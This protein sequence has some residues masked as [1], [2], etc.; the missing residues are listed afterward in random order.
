M[1][2]IETNNL[3]HTYE[4]FERRIKAVRSLTFSIPQGSACALL[5]SNGAGKTTTLKMLLNLL[6]PTSG[7]ATVLGVDSRKLAPAQFEQIGYVS[8]NQKLPA[9]DTVRSLLNFCRA[10][11]PAWD[12]EFEARLLKLFELPLDRKLTKLSR[13][14]Q[15]KAKLLSSLAYHPK[16]V[17]MDEPFSGLDPL[18]R[19]ELMQGVL[20]LAGAGDWTM[21]ISS[22]DIDDVERL[23]DRVA[24]IEAGILLFNEPLDSLQSRHRRIHATFNQGDATPARPTLPQSCIARENMGNHA[25]WIE[26]TFAAQTEEAYRADNPGATFT[27]QPMTLKEIYLATVKNSASRK[28]N[29]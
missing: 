27:T 28:G 17:V 9:W 11:Y 10:L 21:L 3:S 16:L 25:S 29:E 18:G 14:M 19:E 2:I 6:R 20:D 7:T 8:E 12:R 5:G 13:G 1:H 4:T 26:T 24:I 15:M 23:V 22:H